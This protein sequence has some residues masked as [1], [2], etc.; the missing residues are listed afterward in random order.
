MTWRS[1][2]R[3]ENLVKRRYP[4]DYKKILKHFSDDALKVIR[5]RGVKIGVFHTGEL[6]FFKRMKEYEEGEWNGLYYG[7][8]GWTGAFEW[9]Y[10]LDESGFFGNAMYE[11]K[12]VECI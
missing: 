7:D 11:L 12:A 2:M 10:S 9:L 6:C 1:K 8:S 4:K 5:N 3:I